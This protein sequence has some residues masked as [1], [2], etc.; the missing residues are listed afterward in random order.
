VRNAIPACQILSATLR[1]LVTGWV[2]EDLK[3]ITAIAHKTLGRTPLFLMCPP[4]RQKYS[5]RDIAR[6]SH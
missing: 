1:F 3:F 6:Y 4:W 2:F 5:W